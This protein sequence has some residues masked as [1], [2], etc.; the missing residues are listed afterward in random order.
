MF[1]LTETIAAIASPP[2]GALRGIVRISGP[3][4]REVLEQ[5]C[6]GLVWPRGNCRLEVPL[7]LNSPLG[8]VD[9]SVCVW[10]SE[11]SYT[12]MPSAEIHVAGA[13]PILAATLSAMLSA[14]ARMAHPGEFTLRSF[15]AGKLDLTEAEA[16]LGV[17]DAE[18]KQTLNGALRQLAGGIGRPL[19]RLRTELLNLLAHLEAGLDFVEED[20]EFVSQQELLA[21]VGRIAED[22]QTIRDQMRQRDHATGIPTV[23]FR[24]LPNAGKSSL[25]NA[26]SHSESAIVSPEAGTTRDWIEVVLSI[27]SMR[28]RLIDTAGM[29]SAQSQIDALAQ[30]SGHEVAAGAMVSVLCV[31]TNR[32]NLTAWQASEIEAAKD[33]MVLV[34]TKH[35]LCD[36]TSPTETFQ[37]LKRLHD[38]DR[39]PVVFSSSEANTGIETLKDVIAEQIGNSAK[40]ESATVASTAVRC[41]ECLAEALAALDQ[42]VHAINNSQGDELVA[43]EL[44]LAL[45]AIGRVTGE[46]YTDD[47]LDRIFSEFCIGK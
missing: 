36:E 10:P 3:N 18:D 22:V 6:E 16:V 27:R 34:G 44:R 20:I 21:G 5:A 28:V 31:A 41:R 43:A 2:G 12:G 40:T 39:F 32:P 1:D 24:G 45:D 38:A 26:L 13:E 29:E 42:A 46:V 9:A 19:S 7:A 4:T 11:R 14:G 23:V 35:D 37:E 25:V 30:S 33:N 15:L 8:K 17:I 47:I